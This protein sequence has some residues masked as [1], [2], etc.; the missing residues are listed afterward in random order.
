MQVGSRRAPRIKRSGP[1]LT[2]NP[3]PPVDDGRPRLR[4]ALARGN[5]ALELERPLRLGPLRVVELTTL[6]PDI[7]FPVDLSGGVAKFRHRR[8][9][10]LKL[11]VEAKA[12]DLVTHVTPRLKGAI[13]GG[14]ARVTLA[15]GHAALLVG[16]ATE[17]AALAF[18]LVLAPAED[19]VRLIVDAPRG[20]ALEAPAAFV[21]MRALG[22]IFKHETAAIGSGLT[23]ADV[24]RRLGRRVLPECGARAPDARGVRLW[25]EAD[26]DRLVLSGELEGPEA[27]RDPRATRAIELSQLTEEGDALAMSGRLE[28]ARAAYLAALERAP[29]HAEI[30]QRIVEIDAASGDRFDAALGMLVDLGP[31]VDAGGAGAS[32]LAATGDLEGARE[33]FVRAARLEAYGGL[34]AHQLLA[35]AALETDRRAARDLVDEAVAR[36]PHLGVARWRRF[37]NRVA[38]GEIHAAEAE[39]E[40][41]E[42]LASSSAERLESNRRIGQTF[43]DLGFSAEAQRRFVRALRFAPS[44]PAATLGLATAFRDLGKLDRATD[45]FSR[46]I[47]QAEKKGAR[48]VG[49][50]L[51][52]ARLLATYAHDRPAAIARLGGIRPGDPEFWEARVLDAELRCEIGDLAGASRSLARMRAHAEALREHDADAAWL[53]WMKRAARIEEVEL[54]DLHAAE[55]TW[56]TIAHVY[57]RERSAVTELRRVSRS[58]AAMPPEAVSP[59]AVSP[60]GAPPRAAPPDAMPADLLAPLEVGTLPPAAAQGEDEGVNEARIERLTEA[61][62]GRPDDDDVALELAGLLDGLARDLDLVALAS[63]RIEEESP[64]KDDF[65]SFRRRAFLRLADVAAREGREEEASFYRSMAA[66]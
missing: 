30:V 61:L 10:L 60:E 53:A 16:L 22:M 48:A 56:I 21:A 51:E 54:S 33:A 14:A 35:A 28:E 66:G 23:I 43:L 58:R 44:D 59:E 7:R 17:T 31:A 8:G 64:R 55:R 41:L 15:I 49:A 24:P 18:D 40:H 39:A 37:E 52:L 11:A 62:R 63:A 20:H 57:P 29:R 65:V 19:G 4:L 38:L 1:A 5:L 42:A 12:S 45:L 3:R 46:A 50:E 25:L 27:A 9:K 2:S 13:P 47:A 26:A 36:A 32:L 6:V 34:A